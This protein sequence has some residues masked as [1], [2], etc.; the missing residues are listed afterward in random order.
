MNNIE[1]YKFDVI[2]SPYD[3]RDWNATLCMV[4]LN[5]IGQLPETLDYR[6][7]LND[8][9]DQLREGS[10]AAMASCA[11][12][13][14]QERIDCGY[15][16][17]F[18]PQFIYNQRDTLNGMHSRRVMEILFKIG[19]IRESMYKYGSQSSI[20]EEMFKEA[21]NFTINHYARV[22]SV[23]DAKNSLY[24]TGPLLIAV[25]VFGSSDIK[26]MWVPNGPMR[27]GHMMC[28]VGYTK[29]SFIIRNS[30]GPKWGENGYCYL[31]FDHWQYI[32]EVWTTTDADSPD[33]PPE[34]L[35]GCSSFRGAKV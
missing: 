8:A 14:V 12:K 35:V 6:E 30:W 20:T 15:K 17:Y 10:C 4:P 16:G 32:W 28:I 11:V 29:D 7:Y 9:R 5:R 13:E 23:I 18:S 21:K 24:Q 2:P 31:P 27:G 3:N 34:F 19:V 33:M 1:Q 22:N 26:Y 25:P